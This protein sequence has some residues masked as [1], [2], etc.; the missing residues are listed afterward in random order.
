MVGSNPLPSCFPPQ[1]TVAPLATLSAT[2]LATLSY[3]RR[4][5]LRREK[6]CLYATVTYLGSYENGFHI[7]FKLILKGNVCLIS[8]DPIFKDDNE[9]LLPNLQR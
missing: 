5:K 2:I 3:I 7:P 6:T 1:T 4:I 9:C 8:S